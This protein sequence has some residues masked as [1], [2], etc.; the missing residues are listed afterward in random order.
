MRGIGWVLTAMI[1][2]PSVGQTQ[3]QQTLAD[4][5]QELTVLHVEIQR[6]KREFSTTGAPATNLS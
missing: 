4:I 2:L 6:L 3:D 5:R 1:A